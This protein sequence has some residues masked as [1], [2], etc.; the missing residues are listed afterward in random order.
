M[1]PHVFMLPKKDVPSAVIG[2]ICR[3]CQDYAAGLEASSTGEVTRLQKF[4]RH[5]CWV[6]AASQNFSWLQR[7]PSAVGHQMAVIGQVERRLPR[8]R[9][10]IQVCHFELDT[11]LDGYP[12]EFEST[13]KIWLLRLVPVIGRAVVFC[14]GCNR[15]QWLIMTCSWPPTVSK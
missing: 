12:M 1:A 7:A 10:V 8:Q 14:T 5:N 4:C 2:T 9:L 3:W 6:F 13:G 15:Q 11:L